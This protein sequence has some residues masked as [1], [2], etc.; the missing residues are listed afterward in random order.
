M[1]LSLLLLF[2]GL[3]WGNE[4][5]PAERVH[6][7]CSGMELN[8]ACDALQA[9]IDTLKSALAANEVE[10]GILAAAC[11]AVPNPIAKGIACAGAAGMALTI[12]LMKAELMYDRTQANRLGCPWSD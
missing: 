2:A 7:E 1:K 5:V 4:H 11:A 10:A 9:Q 6:T 12:T 3:A 8:D